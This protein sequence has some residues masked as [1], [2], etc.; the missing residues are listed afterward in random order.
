[1]TD[2]ERCEME[3]LVL[4][5]ENYAYYYHDTNI[6]Y[7]FKLAAKELRRRLKEEGAD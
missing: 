1:M 3:R 5:Y 6:A 2:E 4:Q 7:L